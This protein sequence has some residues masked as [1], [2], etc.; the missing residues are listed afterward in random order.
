MRLYLI[1]LLLTLPFVVCAS[2][3][4]KLKFVTD[5]EIRHSQLYDALGIKI[6]PW[7]KFWKEKAPKIHVKI[8]P[9]FVESLRYYY[10]SQGF[11]H[12]KIEKGE[13]AN[14]VI[15]KITEG[16]RT[17]VNSVLVVSDED[18][19]DLVTFKKGD[20]F[21]SI[22]FVE[23]K[24]NIKNRLQ[25]KGY[26]NFSLDAKARVDIEKNSVKLNYHLNKNSQCRFGKITIN[27]PK[28]IKD[29]ITRSRLTFREGEIYDL[30][31]INR[32]YSTI[33]GLEV[34]DEIRVAMDKKNDI[35]DINI[36]LKEK[37]KKRRIEAGIGYETDIGPRGIF[38]FEKRNFMGNA[39]KASLDF[40][41]SKKEKFAKNILY[42]PAFVKVPTF[43]YYYLDLKNEFSYSK[44]NFDNFDE[45]KYSNYLHLLK[46]YDKFSV[47]FGLGLERININKT[48][49]AE[50]IIDGNFNLFFPFAKISADFRDSKMNP[51]NGFYISLYVENG[52]DILQDSSTYFKSIGEARAIKT[53]KETTIALKGKLGIIKEY[54]NS[55]PASKLFF[56]GGAF[57]N[58][59]YGYNTLGAFDKKR[60]LIGGRTLIDTTIEINHPIYKKF[61]GAVFFDSTLL[62][63]QSYRFSIDIVHSL[64]LGVRYMTAI[65]PVK[66]DLGVDVEDTSQYAM[67]FQIGQSF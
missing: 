46:D 2:D 53:I 51:K 10:K 47:N 56:A 66:F 54:A 45:R 26:C 17:K 64:G 55:L 24:K 27:S 58:R 7:Y 61:E 34:F 36:D 15:F 4:K 20:V 13:T 14:L 23:I 41:Y 48:E 67:H 33:S 38:H 65:G 30:E 21:N 5:N 25:K 50:N 49:I 35:I 16:K 22:E 52:L 6:P 44:I 39:R 29:N 59:G 32:S 18:I 37:E 1:A 9:S 40:K 8:I 43:D 3:T 12:A 11:Y 62:S 19:S 60:S 31:K 63:S 42:W 28:N 57:S